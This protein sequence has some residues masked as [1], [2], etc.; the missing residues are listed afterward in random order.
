[1]PLIPASCL[2]C[3]GTLCSIITME[4]LNCTYRLHQL[5]M[6]TLCL[7][8]EQH[9]SSAATAASAFDVSIDD[10]FKDSTAYTSE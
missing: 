8:F 3:V 10:V 9:G 2:C 7:Q 6:L 4:T 1:M 5:V